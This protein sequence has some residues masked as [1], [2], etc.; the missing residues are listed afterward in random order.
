MAGMKLTKRHKISLVVL[1]LGLLGLVVDRVLL[2][3]RSAAGD[4]VVAVDET[5]P[6]V[7]M[8]CGRAAN[9]ILRA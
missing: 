9:L 5:S 8:H 7:W 3:P 1:A 2:F 4:E 6:V